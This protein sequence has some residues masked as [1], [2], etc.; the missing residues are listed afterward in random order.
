LCLSD[1]TPLIS[2]IGN[3]ISFE[4]VFS[5]QLKSYARPNDLLV[6]VTGSGNSR[7]II[8]ACKQAKLIGMQVLALTG[9]DGG[10]T[11]LNA[12]YSF[13]C[14]VEDMQIVEDMHLSFGHLVIR[15]N[16]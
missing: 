6:C 1:N 14:P 15:C 9:F 2:A 8:N 13:H 5:Y 16:N 4:E 7:N 10:Q 11:L 3:D 12:D